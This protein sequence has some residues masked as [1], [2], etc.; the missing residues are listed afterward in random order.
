MKLDRLWISVILPILSIVVIAT[1][2][3]SGKELLIEKEDISPIDRQWII[4]EQNY[5][6]MPYVPIQKIEITNDFIFPKKY[7]LPTLVGCLD[8]LDERNG[9][10]MI[11]YEEENSKRQ[12]VDENNPFFYVVSG[13]DVNGGRE[14][15][16][17]DVPP[18]SKKRLTVYVKPL[19][20]HNFKDK[21]EI[22]EQATT[23]V[24]VGSADPYESSCRTLPNL[25]TVEH[26][27]LY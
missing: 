5:I 2:S 6:P 11:V 19:A 8:I 1:L 17:I 16:S 14:I 18:K 20:V 7:V 12:P 3:N 25:E 23:L 13:L 22:Y 24:L 26:I 4:Y 27:T 10:L 9:P 15:N 21:K